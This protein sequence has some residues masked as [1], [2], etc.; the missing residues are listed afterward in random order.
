VETLSDWRRQAWTLSWLLLVVVVA[1]FLRFNTT[2]YQAQARY[3]FAAS[4]PIVLLLTLG[5]WDLHRPK[6]GLYAV[7]VALGIMLVMSLSSVFGFSA[8]VAAHYPPPFFGG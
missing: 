2:F 7:C 5:L 6:Y 3:L 4:G 1:F 8:I